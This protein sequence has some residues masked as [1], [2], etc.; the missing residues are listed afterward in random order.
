M[1]REDPQQLFD[2]Q[3]ATLSNDATPP[4]TYPI[5]SVSLLVRS[6]A[7]LFL[8]WN[9][10]HDPFETLRKA[11]GSE[12]AHYRLVVRLIDVDS[13]YETFHEALPARMQWFD[14]SPGRAY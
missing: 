9:H 14:V 12:A 10:A 13:G 3:G 2:T 6:P 4:Q 8:C 1:S 11:F 7:K 5:D